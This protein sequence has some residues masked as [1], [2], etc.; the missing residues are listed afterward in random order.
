[1]FD[2]YANLY[3]YLQYNKV[4]QPGTEYLSVPMAPSV[5]CSIFGFSRST[6]VTQVGDLV[7][8]LWVLLQQWYN[9]QHITI[10][11]TKLDPEPPL[12]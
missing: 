7:S 6:L 3:L 4:Y 5:V 1:M 2:I 10:G 11:K 9:K 12:T 8:T